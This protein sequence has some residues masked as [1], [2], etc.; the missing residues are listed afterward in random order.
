M[1]DVTAARRTEALD[2]AGRE[3]REVVVVDVALASLDA[4]VVE[5]LFFGG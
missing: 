2:F 3:W 1:P 4:E 5:T